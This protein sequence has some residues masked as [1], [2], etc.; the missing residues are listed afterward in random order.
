M[1]PLDAL[2]LQVGDCGRGDSGVAAG[3]K[4]RQNRV[5]TFPRI[6]DF[7]LPSAYREGASAQI[8]F[9]SQRNYLI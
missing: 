4:T 1:P 7:R 9:G 8:A 2:S 3:K 5:L 6:S